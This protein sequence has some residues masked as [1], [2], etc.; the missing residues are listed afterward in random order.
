MLLHAQVYISLFQITKLNTGKPHEADKW[1][2]VNFWW[3]LDMQLNSGEGIESGSFPG[4]L[5]ILCQVFKNHF[6]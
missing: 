3:G 4:M 1:Y 5:N 2:G 6:Q